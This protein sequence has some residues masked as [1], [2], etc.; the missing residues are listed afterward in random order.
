MSR[1]YKRRRSI[2]RPDAGRAFLRFLIGMVLLV[3]LCA[4]FYIFVLQGEINIELPVSQPQ[5]QAPTQV[6]DETVTT[7]ELDGATAGASTEEPT[8]VL[9]NFLC[10]FLLF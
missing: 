6:P 5:Q 3:A 2:F 10:Y 8:A 9:S 1:G 4:L 7:S